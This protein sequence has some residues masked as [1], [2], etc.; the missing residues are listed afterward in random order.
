MHFVVRRALLPLNHHADVNLICQDSLDTR[1][2]P[3]GFILQLKDRIIIDTA[4]KLVF[5]RGQNTK[6]IQTVGNLA[7][8]EAIFEKRKD[9]LNDFACVFIYDQMVV[10]LR[11]FDVA[12][13]CIGS[14]KL[15]LPALYIQICPYLYRNIFALGIVDQVLK[16]NDE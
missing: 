16:G 8:A 3:L 12:I 1:I 14:N 6:L 2:R 15:A 13:R 4:G 11:V 9:L 7:D 5:H 10:V